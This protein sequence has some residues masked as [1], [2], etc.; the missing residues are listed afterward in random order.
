MAERQ[1]PPW[2][3]YDAQY[4]AFQDA[5][6]IPVHEGLAIDDVRTVAVDDWD[7]TGGC[8]AFVNLL[9]MEGT[10]DVHLHDLPPATSTAPQRHL[11]GALVFVVE[12][13]GFTAIGEGDRRRVFEWGPG[14]LFYLPRNT[15]YAHSAAGAEAPVRLLAVTPLP[16]LYTVLQDDTAIWDVGPY[17]QWSLIDDDGF[18]ERSARLLA[19]TTDSRTYWDA[20]FV[21]DAAEFDQLDAW[22][23]RGGGGRTVHFPFRDTSMYA[24]ISEFEAGRYKKAHRHHPG[25]NVLVLGGEGYSLLWEEGDDDRTRVDWTPYTLFTPPMMWFHQHFNTSSGPA[26]YLAM[27]AP[28]LGIRG[29]ENAAIE[30]LNPT[31]QIEYHE[32]DLAIREEFRRELEAKGLESR[33][34]ADRYEA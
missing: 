22:P 17:E 2:E 34:E 14:S 30:A 7:R 21:H 29:G 28:Q 23:E 20:N 24:H 11:F 27:H 25:A 15:R 5:E 33:M 4:R 6:G 26:R 3:E 1:T 8:G 10:C 19:G 18:Y 13:T 31:N 32:E 16:L 12:G 9:G